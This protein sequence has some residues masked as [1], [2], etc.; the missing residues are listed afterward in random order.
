VAGFA[1]ESELLATIKI[2]PDSAKHVPGRYSSGSWK[3]ARNQV[4]KHTMMVN[5]QLSKVLKT[6]M[7]GVSLDTNAESQP[8]LIVS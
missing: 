7:S 4:W 3:V 8:K 6:Q 1:D 5:S 2:I